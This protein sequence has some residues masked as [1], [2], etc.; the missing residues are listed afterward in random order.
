M[1]VNQK[2]TVFLLL[3]VWA[4]AGEAQ[5]DTLRH[6]AEKTCFQIYAPWRAEYDIRAD[7]AIVYGMTDT[8]EERVRVWKEHGYGVHFMTGIA[9][10]GYQDYFTGKFD[11]KTHMEDGQVDCEGKIIWHSPDVPYVVPSSA[12]L[13]YIKS[14]VKRAIDGGVT[15]IHLEEPE[16]WARAGYSES[17]KKEWQQYYGFPWMAQH[18]SAEATYLSAKL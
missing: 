12:Y 18:K 1:I 11:G 7:V 3:L 6:T 5:F 14:L 10:G 4:A 16:F 9:W 8:F 13:T 15:A 2:I 17:F